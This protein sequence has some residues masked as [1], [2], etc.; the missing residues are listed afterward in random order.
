MAAS[1]GANDWAAMAN[2]GVWKNTSSK[3]HANTSTLPHHETLSRQM[4]QQNHIHAQYNDCDVPLAPGSPR[5]AIKDEESPLHHPQG[6]NT[7]RSYNHDFRN[8]HVF[9]AQHSPGSQEM[10]YRKHY[11]DE[12]RRK[13]HHHHGSQN[14]NH[15][16]SEIASQQGRIYRRGS[17]QEFRVI[18][19]DPVYEEIERNET[20]MSDMSDDNS[21]PDNCRQN[22]GHHGSTSSKFFGDHRP[23]ISYS[24]GDRHLHEDHYGK[25][26]K[27]DTY[28]PRH[29]YESGRLMHPYHQPQENNM[30]AL[31]AVLNGENNVVCHLEPHNSYDVYQAQPGNPRTVS[32]PSF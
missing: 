1:I 18:Q 27:W 10:I 11:K 20:L 9:M 28:D 12:N 3:H 5:H 4:A 19:D 22:V 24:P 15:T 25:Y 23:L 21:G 7:T 31:A 26:G 29:T 16:Y 14:V 17:E 30:R 2:A 8:P 13:H 6:Y 32:Q